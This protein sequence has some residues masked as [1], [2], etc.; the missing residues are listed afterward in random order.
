[1][2][3]MPRTLRAAAGALAVACALTACGTSTDSEAPQI[4]SDSARAEV[5]R[6]LDAVIAAGTTAVQVVVTEDGRDWQA[7]AGVGDVGTGAGFPEDARVRAG[8]NTKA[9]AATV[10]M[11][12]VT[13][14]S[15]H[16]DAPAFAGAAGALVSTGGELSPYRARPEC[17]RPSCSGARSR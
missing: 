7:T 10:I 6:A 1:M 14:G 16:L 3:S 4:L 9:F 8:S 11:Q 2:T 5:R 13:A 15:V 12:L 17:R